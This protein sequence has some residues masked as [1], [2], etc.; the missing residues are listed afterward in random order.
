MDNALSVASVYA[1]KQPTPSPRALRAR[2]SVARQIVA[3]AG[4]RL[5]VFPAG[6]LWA[7]SAKKVMAV[8]EPVLAAARQHDVAV[9]LGVDVQAQT[10]TKTGDTKTMT[11]P[12][13]LDNWCVAWPAKDPERMPWKQRSSTSWNG[14]SVVRPD[15]RRALAVD[16]RV[17][18]V[19]ICGEIFSRPI[20]NA[21]VA[22]RHEVDLVAVPAHTAQ[23]SR[24][25]R[26]LQFLATNGLPALRSVHAAHPAWLRW[27]LWLPDGSRP[28]VAATYVGDAFVHA[29]FTRR[30]VP[31]VRQVT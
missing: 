9:V 22:R 11:P 25:G 12:A 21:L 20:R 10:G 26:G 6:F 3:E 19:L 30:T 16:G 27:E 24:H 4:A 28:D 2:L 5:V 17:V 8:A 14:F 13:A 1:P 23:G 7:E 15:A 18:E 29:W 31:L